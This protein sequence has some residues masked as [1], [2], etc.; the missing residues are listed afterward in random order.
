MKHL[1]HIFILSLILIGINVNSQNLEQTRWFTNRTHVALAKVEKEM[2]KA[3][4][5][6]NGAELKKA[7]K[8]QVIALNLS[9]QNNFK[10]AVG[11]SFKARAL[12]IELCTKMNISEGAFYALNDDEKVYC[13][14]ANYNNLSLNQALLNNAQIKQIDDLD[15]LDI[16]KF[17]QIDLNIK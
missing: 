14:P 9:K 3:G 15:I 5:G 7:I 1:K 10:D 2:Y 13:N 6:A 12:C 16:T 17:H 8:L 11:Y 4:D